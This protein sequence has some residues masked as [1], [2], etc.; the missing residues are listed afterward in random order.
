MP[1]PTDCGNDPRVN[2]SGRGIVIPAPSRMVRYA[3]PEPGANTTVTEN[4]AG[5]RWL[6]LVIA[7]AIVAYVAFK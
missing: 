3:T 6:L 5:G 2:M 1:C 7:G 4:A